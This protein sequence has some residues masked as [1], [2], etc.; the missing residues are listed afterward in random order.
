MYFQTKKTLKINN[1]HTPK[2]TL[3]SWIIGLLHQFRLINFIKE[4]FFFKKESF[5]ILT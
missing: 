4:A 5:L 2:H 1:Y 3:N